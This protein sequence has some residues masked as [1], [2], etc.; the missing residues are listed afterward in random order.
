[1]DPTVRIQW[2]PEPGRCKPE[3]QP[4]DHNPAVAKGANC[5]ETRQGG[6]EAHL[7]LS[8]LEEPKSSAGSDQASL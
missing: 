2:G 5:M 7:S 1:M 4:V 6:K 3:I 8:L